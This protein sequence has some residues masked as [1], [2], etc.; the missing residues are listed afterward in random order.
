M[1]K[2]AAEIRREFHTRSSRMA[3]TKEMVRGLGHALPVGLEFRG[4]H[5]TSELDEAAEK[6]GKHKSLPGR[7]AR[8]VRS[9]LARA[10]RRSPAHRVTNRPIRDQMD[11]KITDMVPQ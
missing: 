2:D 11:S 3:G 10:R 7:P 8:L 6:G 4:E 9:V 1:G 5:Q